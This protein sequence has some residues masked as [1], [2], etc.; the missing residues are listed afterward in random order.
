MTRFN[1]IYYTFYQKEKK[2]TQ[3]SSD[4]Y[5]CSI[6]QV[7]PLL[8]FA[9]PKQHGSL[10]RQMAEPAPATRQT[11]TPRTA[12][13]SAG[14]QPPGRRDSDKK[15]KNMQFSGRVECVCGSVSVWQ[16]LGQQAPYWVWA[17]QALHGRDTSPAT[18]AF[19]GGVGDRAPRT[20]V[21]C[22]EPPQPSFGN[23]LGSVSNGG[24][25]F[26]N[27]FRLCYRFSGCGLNGQGF[28]LCYLV[29][30]FLSKLIGVFEMKN[31]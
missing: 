14:D 29:V 13:G 8:S 23:D 9:C 20:V 19:A 27:D 3:L 10:A 18:R 12:P 21:T 1:Q 4:A 26:K 17:L 28:L 30:Q 25:F 7:I 16:L 24:A 5:R 11:E 22:D 6:Y 15:K 2:G 31:I